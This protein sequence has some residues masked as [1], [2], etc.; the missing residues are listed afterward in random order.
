MEAPAPSRRERGGPGGTGAPAGRCAQSP[1]GTPLPDPPPPSGARAG[2]AARPLTSAAGAPGWILPPEVRGRAPARGEHFRQKRPRGGAG[3]GRA[4]EVGRPAQSPESQ[5]QATC[6]AVFACV[7]CA[8][9]ASFWSP[10]ACCDGMRTRGSRKRATCLLL[11]NR[12]PYSSPVLG[13][14][15]TA[16]MKNLSWAFSSESL[17]RL[18]SDKSGALNFRT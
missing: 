3:R 1:A 6:R 11:L 16:N 2:P 13:N 17:S 12:V 4:P 5:R 8:P 7:S 10:S 18:G 9:S 15:G 14:H